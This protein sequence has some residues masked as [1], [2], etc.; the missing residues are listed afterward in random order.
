MWLAVIEISWVS[1]QRVRWFILPSVWFHAVNHV[2]CTSSVI[3]EMASS[4][5]YLVLPNSPVIPLAWKST[6]LDGARWLRP[7]VCW[8]W[9]D[10]H[11]ATFFI[12]QA[13]FKG[14]TE[15]LFNNYI[16]L[17]WKLKECFIKI[18]KNTQLFYRRPM[19]LCIDLCKKKLSKF[20]FLIKLIF[21]CCC[22][23]FVSI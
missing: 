12:F 5:A 15:F 22:L 11:G 8:N 21:F 13:K 1:A 2:S 23:Y 10:P 3:V 6:V 20:Y 17:I 7:C 16:K 18:K 19:F 14:I 9:K 4:P